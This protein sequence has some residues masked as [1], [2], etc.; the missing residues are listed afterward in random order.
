MKPK[1]IKSLKQKEFLEFVLAKYIERGI[2]ELDEEK[3]PKL[4][5]L[6]YHAIADA[7]KIL[8]GVEKIRSTFFDFQKNLYAKL[9]SDPVLNK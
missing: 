5:N 6:K 8:G 4:L 7:E 3:L 1:G 2:E 9:N